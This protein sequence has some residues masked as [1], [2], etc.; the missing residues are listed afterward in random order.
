MKKLITIGFTA[1]TLAAN[2][3]TYVEQSFFNGWNLYVTNG[4]SVAN[5]IGVT[6]LLFTTAQGQIVYSLTNQVINGILNTNSIVGDAYDTGG[7]GLSFNLNG[8]IVANGAIHYAINYTNLIPIAITNSQGQWYTSNSWPLQSSQY[9]IYQYPA[10]TN[11]YPSLPNASDTNLV[12]LYF[13]RGWSYPLGNSTSYVFWDTSTNVF[14]FSITGTGFTPLAGI[15]NLPIA[16]TQGANRVRLTS[17]LATTN[18]T[19]VSSGFIINQVS[20]GQP[21]P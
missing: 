20:L 18:T 19:G 21:Q 7:N 17:V 12:T 3:A 8:D 13:Q 9:P 5:G 16:F 6:N 14:S 2:A 15:T 4:P 10:T 11:V 1:L